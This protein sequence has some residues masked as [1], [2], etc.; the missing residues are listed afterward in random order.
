[1]GW[2]PVGGNEERE[3]RKGKGKGGE[4]A[5][6]GWVEEDEEW[7]KK[8]S[9]NCAFLGLI[10]YLSPFQSILKQK[11]SKTVGADI[12]AY[13]IMIRSI[14]CLSDLLVTLL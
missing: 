7:R 12:A 11:Y 14:F 3:G 6:G 4:G 10:L 2:V 1:M 13:C 8:E 9:T 5:N